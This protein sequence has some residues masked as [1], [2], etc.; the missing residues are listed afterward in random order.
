MGYGTSQTETAQYPAAIPDEQLSE[1]ENGCSC[2]WNVGSGLC[3]VVCENPKELQ[4]HI[5][6]QHLKSLNK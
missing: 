3:G 1:D 6:E 4:D 2:K 5:T